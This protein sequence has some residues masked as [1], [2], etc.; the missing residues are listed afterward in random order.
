MHHYL[1]NYIFLKSQLLG[2]VKREVK[3][4]CVKCAQ[5][6]LEPVDQAFPAS[7]HLNSKPQH[8]DKTVSNNFLYLD[9]TDK[10][11]RYIL[12]VLILCL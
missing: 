4:R 7:L 8:R 6:I 10:I 1:I 12:L 9:K 2:L 5:T 3:G 11:Y